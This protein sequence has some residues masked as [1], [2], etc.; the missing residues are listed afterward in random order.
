[1][2]RPLSTLNRPLEPHGLEPQEEAIMDL[3]DATLSVEQIAARLDLSP[4]RVTAVVDN[5][6]EG[7]PDRWQFRAR[8]ATQQLGLA[9]AKAMAA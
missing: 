6:G 4:V 8:A 9:L 3:W 2:T 5:Y 1:M 7:R